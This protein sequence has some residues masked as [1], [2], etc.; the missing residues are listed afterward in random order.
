[1]TTLPDPPTG[2][3]AVSATKATINKGPRNKTD[4]GLFYCSICVSTFFFAAVLIFYL[5]YKIKT[6]SELHMYIGNKRANAKLW[7]QAP[8]GDSG[9]Y[10]QGGLLE[11]DAL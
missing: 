3:S 10:P 4:A 2:Y 1:M 11:A 8:T 9:M 6:E 5:I 7:F